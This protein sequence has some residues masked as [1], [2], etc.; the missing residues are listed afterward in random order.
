MTLVFGG[1]SFPLVPVGDKIPQPFTDAAL[2]YLKDAIN[3][4]VGDAF[5]ATFRGKIGGHP[6][7][8]ACQETGIS[9]PDLQSHKVTVRLPYLALWAEDGQASEGTL[10][11]DNVETK[12]ALEY[13]LPPMP[14]GT[15][16]DVATPLLQAVQKLLVLLV[17]AGTDPSHDGGAMVWEDAGIVSVRVGRWQIV[18]DALG[19]DG[20][21][22]QAF[23]MLQAEV[24]VV[25]QEGYATTE[26]ETLDRIDTSLDV[27]SDDGVHPDTV[28]TYFEPPLPRA[29]AEDTHH[30][31]AAILR[32]GGRRRVLPAR[33]AYRP[34][35]ADRKD[36]KRRRL[37]VARAGAG[38]RH[39]RGR[40]HCGGPRLPALRGARRAHS[41]C[42]R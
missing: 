20:P 3:H 13:V 30:D 40:A 35:D 7:T 10:R 28:Q 17:K 26:I 24:F 34:H 27:A 21:T 22:T 39:A 19:N 37:H 2:P 31:H 14:F 16:Q 36:P 33:Y 6:A 5:T 42:R 15:I 9:N 41:R 38:G 18:A 23:P 8:L 11:W 4:Y 25:E 1:L 29:S 12:Y 32:G